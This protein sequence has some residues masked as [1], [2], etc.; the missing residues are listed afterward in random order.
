M[1][2]TACGGGTGVDT[3]PPVITLEGDSSIS[4]KE[5]STFSDPGATAL[6]DTDGV[7]A[8]AVSGS[9]DVNVVDSYILVYSAIDTAG[10]REEVQRTVTVTA[11]TDEEKIKRLEDSGEIPGNLDRTGNMSGIDADN[12]GVRDDIDQYISTHY[13]AGKKRAAATQLARNLQNILLSNKSDLVNLKKLNR[14]NMRALKCI[15]MNNFSKSPLITIESL[16][17]N[18][19]SRLVEY[20]KYAK[21]LDGTVSSVPQ[22][23]TCE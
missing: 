21:A 9:V 17:T 6:D 12:N 1:L 13:D 23:D 11:L 7:V 20:L 8:V 10:N 4:I 3:T 18:T 14:E 15:H 2:L 5:G 19:K 16:T 22:G